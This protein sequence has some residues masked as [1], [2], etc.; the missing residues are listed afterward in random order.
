[1]ANLSRRDT[2]GGQGMNCLSGR[3]RGSRSSSQLLLPA[4]LFPPFFLCTIWLSLRSSI[5]GGGGREKK[6]GGGALKYQITNWRRRERRGREKTGRG[7]LPPL[8]RYP[9]LLPAKKNHQI[10]FRS[11]GGWM[12]CTE[13]ERFRRKIRKHANVF[14]SY[15]AGNDTLSIRS[16]PPHL[17]PACLLG[18]S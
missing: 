5:G 6:K 9:W 14:L 15:F 10:L 17:F 8:R 12:G 7:P 18:S 3:R 11:G 13:Q 2:R 4:L 1:M 16:F